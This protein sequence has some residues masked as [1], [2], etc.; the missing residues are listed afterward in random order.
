[1]SPY[2]KLFERFGY[3]VDT[4]CFGEN[5]AMACN[6]KFCIPFT[7]RDDGCTSAV[8]FSAD[9]NLNIRKKYKDSS[10][11]GFDVFSDYMNDRGF[12]H[13]GNICNHDHSLTEVEWALSRM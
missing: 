12:H 13:I 11:I 4:N 1:M 2:V 9:E 5:D 3:T 10:T 7:V 6:N 8:S